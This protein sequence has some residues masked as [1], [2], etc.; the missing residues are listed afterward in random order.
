MEEEGELAVAGAI[1]VIEE[2]D[3]EE[4]GE[5]DGGGGVHPLMYNIDL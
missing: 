5:L 1:G 4:E 2:E 3:E